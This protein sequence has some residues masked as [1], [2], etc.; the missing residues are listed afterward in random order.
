MTVA[1]LTGHYLYTVA[2]EV[3]PT[4]TPIEPSEG[5][6]FDEIGNVFSTQHNGKL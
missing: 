1:V 2:E 4:I 3:K 5:L 6:Y